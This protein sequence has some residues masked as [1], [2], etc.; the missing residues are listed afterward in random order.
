[1]CGFLD[2]T[3]RFRNKQ[4]EKMLAK[5]TEFPNPE[6]LTYPKKQKHIFPQSIKLQEKEN[7][8]PKKFATVIKLFIDQ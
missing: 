3:E 8:K 6:I 7:I 1:L 4:L 2:E 5:R